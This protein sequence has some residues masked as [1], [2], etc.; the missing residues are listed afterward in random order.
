MFSTT[1]RIDFD[2]PFGTGVRCRLTTRLLTVATCKRPVHVTSPSSCGLW[3]WARWRYNKRASFFPSIR[4]GAIFC[5][6]MQLFNSKKLFCF[7]QVCLNL[8][9]DY[10]HDDWIGATGW[11]KT[12]SDLGQASSAGD[13]PWPAQTREPRLQLMPPW[14]AGTVTG[15]T[16]CQ[17]CESTHTHQPWS[18][19]RPVL[20]T[21]PPST[22]DTHTMQTQVNLSPFLCARARVCVCILSRRAPAMSVHTRPAVRTGRR[23]LVAGRHPGLQGARHRPVLAAS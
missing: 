11:T 10:Y 22:T 8:R 13:T 17:N 23:R 12:Y 6:H 21:P 5:F 9:V 4:K 14:P 18:S 7:L 19:R 15:V 1:S 2:S 20:S 3:W 16:T